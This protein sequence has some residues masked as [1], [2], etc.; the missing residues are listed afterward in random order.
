MSFGFSVGDFL[1]IIKD[2]HHIRKVF[3]GAPAQF[4]LLN[5]E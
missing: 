5:V 1:G 4:K 3:N 2:I